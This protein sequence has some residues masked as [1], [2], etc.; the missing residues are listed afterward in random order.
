MFQRGL[1]SY[2]ELQGVPQDQ[3]VSSKYMYHKITGAIRFIRPPN[4][5]INLDSDFDSS[6]RGKAKLCVRVS[7]RCFLN[8]GAVG[9]ELSCPAGLVAEGFGA[10]VAAIH[11]GFN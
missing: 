1:E 10:I 9:G 2:A 5:Q 7:E 8:A 4:R 3:R 11:M 6:M